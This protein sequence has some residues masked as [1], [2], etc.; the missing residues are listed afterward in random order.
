MIKDLF[1]KMLPESVLLLVRNYK[2]EK[3]RREFSDLSIAETFSKIYRENLW[4]GDQGEFNSGSGSSGKVAELYLEYVHRFIRDHEI[5]T[6]VDLGC[7]DFR[8]GR[9]IAQVCPQYIGVDVVPEMVRQHIDNDANETVSFRCMD[10]TKD[11]L[12]HGDLCLIRQVLQHLSNEEIASVLCK[13]NDYRFVLITEHF[14]LMDTTF[15]PNKDKPHGS[16]TRILDNSAVV[17]TA[18]PF[19]MQNVQ[20]VL[21]V[22]VDD[23]NI[24]TDQTIRTFLYQGFKKSAP[25]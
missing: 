16:C 2:I 20:E 19:A 23:P 24:L 1:K 15:S 11:M 18:S 25:I 9:E 6:V 7:G 21:C 22:G 12:P 8:I 13:L 4:G 5:K 10:I 14:P 17:L 3:L